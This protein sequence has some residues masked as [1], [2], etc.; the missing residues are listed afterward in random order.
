MHW[1]RAINHHA[2]RGESYVVATVL[3]TTGSA[4]RNAGTKMVI[5]NNREHDTLGGGQLEH[6]VIAQARALLSTA[7]RTQ[8]SS[9]HIEHFPLA[10][11]ALQ[12]CGG[13]VTI[14]FECFAAQTLRVAIFGAGHIGKRCVA[15][16]EELSA[17]VLWFDDAS[18]EPE[19]DIECEVQHTALSKFM[20]PAVAIGDL[21]SAS[22]LVILTHDHQLDYALLEAALNKGLDHFAGVG[23]IGSATKWQRFR[24]RLAA[25]GFEERDINRIRC[26]LGAGA[27]SDKQPMAIAIAIVNELLNLA[28]VAQEK[29]AQQSSG[30]GP[31]DPG[32]SDMSWRQIKSALVKSTQQ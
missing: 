29:L 23:M 10:A 19:G 14:L 4:P 15:L 31:A 20:D 27:A 16:A 9:Q 6:L 30:S 26:P 8:Q 12:C 32:A 1:Y 18:R 21:P 2:A 22:Q 5:V 13:S 28:G 7:Q 3:A 17:Q 11:A 24:K 25:A